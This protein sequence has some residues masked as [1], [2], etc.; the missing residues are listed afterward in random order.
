MVEYVDGRLLSRFVSHNAGE[1]SQK[2]FK[3]V[4]HPN[5]AA[6]AAGDFFSRCEGFGYFKIL[7]FREC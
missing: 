2:H 4:R 1:A 7:S 5:F 6:I 3:I